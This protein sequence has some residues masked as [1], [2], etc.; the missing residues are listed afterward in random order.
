M[1]NYK[2]EIIEQLSTQIVQEIYVSKKIKLS[3]A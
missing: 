1:N 2:T 3:I